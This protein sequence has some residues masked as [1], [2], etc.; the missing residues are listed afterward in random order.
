L[1][2]MFAALLGLLSLALVACPTSRRGG[3]GGFGDDDDDA[4]SADDDDVSDDD[5]AVDACAD[6]RQV[7][8]SGP[9]GTSLNSVLDDFPGMVD[10][11]GNSHSLFE[12]FQD[13]SLGLV[14]VANAFDT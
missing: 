8:P 12:L 3:G 5:D 10:G 14:V 4:T 11:D 13:T 1:R 7:L 9:Y 2:P 6:Y